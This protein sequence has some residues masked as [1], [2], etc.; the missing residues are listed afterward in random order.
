MKRSLLIIA[1][2]FSMF[3]LAIA[4]GAAEVPVYAYGD[5]DPNN[6]RAFVSMPTSGSCNKNWEFEF[7]V[8]AQIAQWVKWNISGTKWT[9]FVRKPGT[10]FTDCIGFTLYSNGD[11]AIDFDGFASPSYATGTSVNPYIDAWYAFGDKSEDVAF[12]TWYSPFELNDQT[13]L[14][15]DSEE[16][17]YGWGTKLWS[18]IKV[19]EC[20]SAS[21]YRDTG[22]ITLTLK[23]QKPWLDDNGY[24]LNNL[25]QFVTDER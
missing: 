5:S 21:T 17:H 12:G 24:Y 22:T 25:E 18:K 11:I 15:P 4:N 23:N 2:V 19:V 13:V 16:L 20:N 10:Y 3:S 7:T 14:F 9:W 6:A 1:I 8:E